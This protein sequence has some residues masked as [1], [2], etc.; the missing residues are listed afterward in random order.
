MA[1]ELCPPFDLASYL[2][3]DLTPVYFGSA[4]NNFGVRELLGAIGEIAPPPRPQPTV[5]RELD[6]TEEAVTGFVFKIQANMDPRHRDRIAFVRLCSGH[7]T[8]G[9]KLNLVRTGATV[10]VHNP[11]MFVARDREL[12]EEAWPG[13]I[14]G[15]PNRGV[16]RIGDALT[17]GEQL[18]FT[19]IP[20]FAP[21]L[22]RKV[23]PVDPMRAKHLG[24]ALL[25]L[26]EEGAAKVFKRDLGGE[27]VVGVVGS[28]QFDVIAD[29]IRTEY[30]IP[31]IFEPSGLETARWLEVDDPKHLQKL[32]S[33]H[34]PAMA[35]DHGGIPVFLARNQWQLDLT[36]REH[37]EIRFLDRVPA[38]F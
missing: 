34:R 15:I 14:I 21:E 37:P 22:L 24:K 16:L 28:L 35:E 13:D 6:P 17:Q 25:Q 2:S 4:L 11:V 30:N 10:N 33:E 32:T 23:R 27:W 20:S 9:M 8:R 3:G 29:R 36:I 12:A 38:G 1:R 19:G 31:V 5:E 26:A 18:H 7:F